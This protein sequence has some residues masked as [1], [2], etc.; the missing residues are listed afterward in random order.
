MSTRGDVDYLAGMG[1]AWQDT[2]MDDHYSPYWPTRQVPLDPDLVRRADDYLA[3]IA[4]LDQRYGLTLASVDDLMVVEPTDAGETL[5]FTDV[6][7]GRDGAVSR[8]V[9]ETAPE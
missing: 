8:H 4:A 7:I 1:L 3:A 5:V 9:A 6:E 2:R